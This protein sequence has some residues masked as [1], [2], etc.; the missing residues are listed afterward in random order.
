MDGKRHGSH[1]SLA[2]IL[3]AKLGNPR[4]AK[5]AAI[6]FDEWY[7]EEFV[8]AVQRAI[9]NRPKFLEQIRSTVNHNGE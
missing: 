6:L 3:L 1:S 4:D 2:G 8:A 7:G 5:L 9:D